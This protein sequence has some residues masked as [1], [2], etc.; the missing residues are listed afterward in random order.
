[1]DRASAKGVGEACVGVGSSAQGVAT[2]AK[3]IALM[4][5]QTKMVLIL[6]S[7]PY[8]TRLSGPETARWP[9]PHP[10]ICL[11]LPLP[12]E[13]FR[14]YDRFWDTSQKVTVYSDDFTTNRFFNT[15]RGIE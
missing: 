2:A 6:F 13:M 12:I 3:R 5:A 4:I 1:M 7:S 15:R 14:F 8:F 11:L 10:K 9:G